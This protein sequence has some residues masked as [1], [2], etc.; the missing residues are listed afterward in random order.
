MHIIGKPMAFTNIWIPNR[1]WASNH[2]FESFAEDLTEKWSR[3]SG[4][5]LV[6]GGKM[7][8]NIA[9]TPTIEVNQ[10]PLKTIRR[11]DLWSLQYK[12]SP[13]LR[14][15]TDHQLLEYGGKLLS[16][17]AL[18][19]LAS[20]RKPSREELLKMLEQTTH[21]IDEM[22]HRGLDWKC[23]PKYPIPSFANSHRG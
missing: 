10:K 17:A 13:Y 22:R 4:R 16:E 6:D 20:E 18:I 3:Y 8:H 7:S 11:Q 15:L 19:Y 5:H 14:P 23:I 9:F 12:K 1:E 21:F 2:W